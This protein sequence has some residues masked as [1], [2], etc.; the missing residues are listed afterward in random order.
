MKI[1]KGS[2]NSNIQNIYYK[3]VL[4]GQFIREVDGY[5][6]FFDDNPNRGLWQAHVLRYI[7]DK[8]DEMNKPYEDILYELF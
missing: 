7:A 8:L 3:D 2:S 5:F 6:Y 1:E 4:V